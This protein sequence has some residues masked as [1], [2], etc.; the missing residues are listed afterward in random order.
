MAF[1]CNFCCMMLF[2]NGQLHDAQSPLFFAD[3]RGFRYGDGLFETIRILDSE[4][5]LWDLHLQRLAKGVQV[6]QLTNGVPS[7]QALLQQ[8]KQLCALNACL[9]V[10]ARLAV[11]RK[12]N[13]EAGYVL[14]LVPLAETFY[15]FNERGWGIGF[16]N[17]VRK[18]NDLLANLK[19]ANYLPYV[20]AAQHAQKNGFDESIIGNVLGQICDGGRTN[21]FFVKH[22]QL[23]TPSL[24]S[25]CVAG[26]M[27]QFIINSCKVNGIAINE[28]S[29]HMDDLLNADEIFLTNAILGIRWVETFG[30]ATYGNAFTAD[31]FHRFVATIRR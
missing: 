29:L 28:S 3:N 9:N 2:C 24:Q 30:A 4:P 13:D 19:T 31:L 11:Y 20:L 27:R 5:L 1:L 25:G 23:Y 12:E 10:R 6:L 17:D 18:S 14:E 7:P 15:T 16:F 26:V 22:A 8:I 21:L